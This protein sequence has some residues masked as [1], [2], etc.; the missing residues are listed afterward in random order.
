MKKGG[1]KE[2]RKEWT[3]EGRH[4]FSYIKKNSF[5]YIFG[6]HVTFYTC[7]IF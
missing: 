4:S 3:K 1:K 2:R 7:V 6:T 5:N